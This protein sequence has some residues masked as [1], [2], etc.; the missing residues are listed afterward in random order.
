M[1][2]FG[3]L[4]RLFGLGGGAKGKGPAKPKKLNIAKTDVSKRFQLL[5]R[6][7]QGSMSK[8]WRAHDSKIGRVVC[9]KILDKEKTAKFEARF[10]GLNRPHEGIICTGLKHRNI[11]QTYEFGLTMQ[12]EMFLVMELIEGDGLNLLIE[13]KSPKLNGKR[14]EYLAQMTD[15][16]EHI[17]RQGFLHR[18]ICP[19]NIMVSSEGVVKWIDFGLAVPNTPEFRRPGNRTGTPN[20]L[21]P[22]LIKRVATD[23]RVDMFALGVTAYELFT[24]W[25]P[26]E[27]A[28]SLQT[29]LSHMNSPGK[30][31]R[32]YRPDLDA[33]T[34]KFLTKAI[35]REPANRFQTAA[36]FKAALLALPKKNW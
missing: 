26:W 4:A 21:A 36:E 3:S 8:V 28:S 24:G 33:A 1:G 34:Y 20:Y 32:E 18:D 31:P 6:V 15:G 14:V 27:K 23:H 30:D 17:H 29:L 5:G 13:T 19:R 2:V 35:E 16:L 11:V 9:L 7:G 25:L 10:P 22:E 12:G